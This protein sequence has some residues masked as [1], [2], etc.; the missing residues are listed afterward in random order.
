MRRHVPLAI[1]SCLLVVLALSVT[2]PLADAAGESGARFNVLVTITSGK[3][4]G[5]EKIPVR[6]YHVLAENGQRTELLDGQ[7][8]PIPVTTFKADVQPIVP[9]TSYTY[10]NVG[11][12]ATLWARDAGAGRV[13]LDGVLEDSRIVAEAA[14]PVIQTRSRKFQALLQDGVPTEILRVQ[15]ADTEDGYIDVTAEIVD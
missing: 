12:S 11:F 7:R 14:Q 6:T 5:L 2:A 8:V 9:M 3:F 15:T 1:P 13:Q 4:Q 10:Q